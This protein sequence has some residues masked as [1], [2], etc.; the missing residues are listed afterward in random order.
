M[1][2]KYHCSWTG[3]SAHLLRNGVPKRCVIQGF[4]FQKTSIM[5]TVHYQFEGKLKKA[6]A[7][8]VAIAAC[9]LLWLDTIIVSDDDEDNETNTFKPT[10]VKETL[11]K[12]E[13]NNIHE[14][15]K[16]LSDAFKWIQKQ[17]NELL[18]LRF[19]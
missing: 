16:D 15:E 11:P 6:R 9:Q 17:T 14:M 10:P 19:K 7:D 3:Y 2:K 8:P 4:E 1:E 18:D 12:L 5:I 13:C